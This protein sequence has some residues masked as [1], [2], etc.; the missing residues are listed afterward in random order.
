MRIEMG[1]IN[2]HV[3]WDEDLYGNLVED[4]RRK[5]GQEV[6]RRIENVRI[7]INRT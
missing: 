4:V 5:A 7:L 1:E 3:R 2:E 6:K